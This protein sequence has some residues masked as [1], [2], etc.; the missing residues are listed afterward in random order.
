M[1]QL[2]ENRAAEEEN[3]ADDEEEGV[4]AHQLFTLRN[5]LVIQIGHLFAE[6]DYGEDE[7]AG[8]DCQIERL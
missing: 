7:D 4:T 5:H 1:E 3:D 8:R 2:V 6:V